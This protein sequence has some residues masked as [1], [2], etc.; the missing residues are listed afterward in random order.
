M[1]LKKNFNQRKVYLSFAM[2]FVAVGLVN[3]NSP[4]SGQNKE[5]VGGPRSQ[6]QMNQQ[7]AQAGMAGNWSCQGADC[8][9]NE[10]ISI[11]A[12]LKSFD[13]YYS[14][15]LTAD[16]NCEV[17]E[18]SVMKVTIAPQAANSSI[19]TA[20]A[21]VEI[22]ELQLA[23]PKTADSGCQAQLDEQN[24]ANPVNSNPSSLTIESGKDQEELT[25]TYIPTGET[26]G[27]TKSYVKMA[28]SALPITE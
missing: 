7:R 25:I 24:K 15:P 3:C 22:G 17:M 5:L 4:L 8:A 26:K 10:M 13:M 27:L 2:G 28:A 16:T 19:L 9:T 1:S 23:S 12:D 11:S 20:S 21:T 14:Q 18:P 6:A